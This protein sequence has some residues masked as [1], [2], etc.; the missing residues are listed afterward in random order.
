MLI[1]L[2]FV[3]NP[4]SGGVSGGVSGGDTGSE[5]S[6]KSSAPGAHPAFVVVVAFITAMHWL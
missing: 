2:I 3:V 1:M 4:S 5:N 6:E